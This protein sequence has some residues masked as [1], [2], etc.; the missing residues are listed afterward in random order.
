MTAIR[1][2]VE[3]LAVNP[4][5]LSVE[6]REGGERHVHIAV[7][8]ATASTPWATLAGRCA[9]ANARLAPWAITCTPLGQGQGLDLAIPADRS[10]HVSRDSAIC[11]S[12]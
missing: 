9:A 7:A 4:D 11:Y 3:T 2:A 1:V 8:D 6:L 12:I 5:L 10:F